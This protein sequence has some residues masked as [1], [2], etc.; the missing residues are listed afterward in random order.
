MIEKDG[1]WVPNVTSRFFTDDVAHGRLG[2]CRGRR[3]MAIVTGSAFE[4][5]YTVQLPASLGLPLDRSVRDARHGRDPGGGA[6]FRPGPDP[7]NAR[8]HGQGV[9]L[10]AAGHQ[11]R[12]GLWRIGTMRGG[13]CCPR[14]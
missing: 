12:K 2:C 11:G 5:R 4:T 10:R 6:A 13:G 3:G 14:P 8:V 1:G 7:P 9:R